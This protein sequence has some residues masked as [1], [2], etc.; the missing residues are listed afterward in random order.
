MLAL[1]KVALSWSTER[2]VL[3]GKC[4]MPSIIDIISFVVWT[5]IMSMVAK[6][7]IDGYLLSSEREVA[8]KLYWAHIGAAAALIIVTRFLLGGGD[9][10]AYRAY[11]GM[12][13]KA[14]LEDFGQYAPELLKLTFRLPSEVPVHVHGSGT[15]NSTGA[16]FGISS[17]LFMITGFSLYGV[18]AIIG[19]LSF[20]SKTMIFVSFRDRIPEAAR[21]WAMLAIVAMPSA[22]FWTAGLLKEGVAVATLGWV[23]YGTRLIVDR[24]SVTRGVAIVVAASLPIYLVKVYILFPLVI[25]CGIW[26]VAASALNRAEGG[27]IQIRP[28][29]LILGLVL[30]TFG[31]AVL[32][33][34]APEYSLNEIGAELAQVQISGTRVG[35]ATNYQLGTSPVG[36]E[37][38][39]AGQLALAPVAFLFALLRPFFFEVSNLQIL[40]NS[41]ESTGL[42][43]LL[44]RAIGKVGPAGIVRTLLGN[45]YLLAALTFVVIFGTAVGL[46]STNVGSLSR[47]RAPM[48]PFYGLL[49]VAI[50]AH[51]F[52]RSTAS[53]QAKVTPESDG[54]VRKQHRRIRVGETNRERRERKN[55]P[56]RVA[57]T[58]TDRAQYGSV[59]GRSSPRRVTEGE[60]P[61]GR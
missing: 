18:G 10:F 58:R 26:I 7:V 11:G 36:A 51:A 25:A 54:R 5:A 24:V 27:K 48:M 55:V 21:K 45:P 42:T 52:A 17:W 57:R 47:Y 43:L 20:I 40:I 8:W 28:I 32:G 14:V 53:A 30:G 2:L 9:M 60:N 13:T 44:L 33:R 56:A 4:R 59:F 15:A 49:L 31:F 41:I 38:G 19:S 1:A 37:A 61:T 46:G 35:G 34:I 6:R 16:M 22:M 39:L 3:R 29:Y 50:P 23:V 12:L